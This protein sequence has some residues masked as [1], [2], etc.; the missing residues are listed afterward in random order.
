MF[1]SVDVELLQPSSICCHLLS[2]LT[3]PQ[4]QAGRCTSPPSRLQAGVQLRSPWGSPLPAQ[5]RPA[6]HTGTCCFFPVRKNQQ[7]LPVPH[8]VQLHRRSSFH[9]V[10]CVCVVILWWVSSWIVCVVCECVVIMLGASAAEVVC[11]RVNVD[12]HVCCGDCVGVISVVE[13]VE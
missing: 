3:F 1:T 8:K 11:V 12:V 13:S 7:L 2:P 5:P 10:V 9:A 4:L 6:A